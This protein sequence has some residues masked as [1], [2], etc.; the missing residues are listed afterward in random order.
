MEKNGMTEGALVLEGGSLRCLFTSGVLDVFMEQGLRF[1][2]VNGVSAGS[3]CGMSYVSG[4]IGRTRDINLNYVHDKR[5]ISLGNMFRKRA[6]FDFDFIFGEL[7]DDLV[8]F[9]KEA[10]EASGQRFLA[11]ATR[12]RTGKPEYFEKGVCSDMMAAVSASCSLPIV[13]HMITVEGKKYLDGGLSMPIPYKKAMEDGYEKVVLVLTRHH[14]YRKGPMKDVKRKIYEKYLG[15]LPEL[16]EAV[17]EIPDRYNRMQ[18]EIDEL[19]AAGK[20]FVIR[21][22]VPVTVSRFER[23]RGKLMALYEEGRQTAVDMLPKLT[24]YLNH[25]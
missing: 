9:D 14:G 13:S 24:A 3:M 17:K 4:Q 25:S 21:P 12:C 23:D 7:S 20:L 19:E 22:P 1:S 10:F 15:P 8:P 2:Y 18:E 11:T 6:L 5:Y 16:L